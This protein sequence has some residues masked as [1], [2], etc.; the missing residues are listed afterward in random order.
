MFSQGSQ[1]LLSLFNFSRNRSGQKQTETD[2]NGHNG[3]KQTEAHRNVQKY[4]EADRKLWK[5]ER[6]RQNGQK[7]TE[8]DRN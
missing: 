2:R 6:N 3:Q 5:T 1:V 4:T 7:L 8:T